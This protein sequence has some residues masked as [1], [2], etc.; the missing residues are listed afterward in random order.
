MK[1]FTAMLRR[2]FFPPQETPTWI[3]VLPYAVLGLLTVA[4]LVGGAYGWEYTNSA[5]FC[6]ET[7]HTMPPE[8]TAYEVSP[9]ARVACVECHLGRGFI[10]TQFTRK[11]GDLRHVVTT[12]F[13]NYE[14]PI[15]A[16]DM[17]PARE[18]MRKMP[19]PGEVLLR[20]PEGNPYLRG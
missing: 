6:G 14:F 7:C 19:L 13:H 9:H 1:K 3:K 20:Q 11:A 12:L 18:F 8:Y 4:L 17:R 16:I 5:P 10:A 2:F 15:R